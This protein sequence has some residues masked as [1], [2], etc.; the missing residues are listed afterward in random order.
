M[1]AGTVIVGA[2]QAGAQLAIS[3]REMGY[4]GGIS[5]I[6]AEPHVPYQRPPL[7]KEF[8]AGGQPAAELSL[9]T[10][11][12]YQE[13][14]IWLRTGAQV[15]SINRR[16]RSISLDSGE[17]LPYERL[18]LATG[19][20][21][22]RLVLSD[23]K[24]PVNVHYLRTIDDAVRLRDAMSSA[25]RI[26]VI[27]AGF[28]G[29]EFASVAAA[30]GTQ[31]TVVELSDR[32]MARAVSPQI[33]AHFAARHSAA[34]TEIICGSVI[35]DYLQ[36]PGGEITGIR[37]NGQVREVDLVLAGIGVIPNAE[38]ARDAGLASEGGITVDSGLG[39]EDPNIF[40]V[41]DCVTHPREGFPSPVRVESV[42][43]AADQAR[44]LA[45]RIIGN[46][47]GCYEEIPWFWSHQAGDKLQIAGLSSPGDSAITLGDPS[48]ARFS[49]CRFRGGI[50]TAVESVN[51]AADHLASR[52]ML[53]SGHPLTEA[54]VRAPGFSLRNASSTPLRASA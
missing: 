34:G 9:R 19:A 32:I 45:R 21:N 25:R 52:R 50:L 30:S 54:E 39:T 42:Q 11:A 8:L 46:Q 31:V 27:G 28:I 44:F 12:Y 3:L 7:S 22:R 24:D 43:N 5:L 15:M 1:S 48:T 40:A 38:L 10:A 33:S 17:L 53:S 13:Q 6:G 49:V 41:G 18:V 35:E 4:L 23:G 36:G 2:G 16:E 26:L 20:R 37:I 51:S 14:D 29:M 47:S